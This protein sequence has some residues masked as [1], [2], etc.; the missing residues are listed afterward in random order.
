MIPVVSTELVYWLFGCP[1][2]NAHNRRLAR[3]DLCM[4]MNAGQL[5][6][7]DTI[8]MFVLRT[9][10]EECAVRAGHGLQEIQD[11]SSI[12]RLVMLGF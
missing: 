3:L 2:R 1:S 9:F 10:L 12:F 7:V 4:K 6:A 8:H 11:H 5:E